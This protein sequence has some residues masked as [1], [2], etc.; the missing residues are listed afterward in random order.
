MFGIRQ[1]GGALSTR[2]DANSISC[3]LDSTSICAVRIC[4]VHLEVRQIA[5]ISDRKTTGRR[6]N[7]WLLAVSLCYHVQRGNSS[8]GRAM[9]IGGTSGS[10]LPGRL[11]A[12]EN[13]N[14]SI[15]LEPAQHLAATTERR[16]LPAG[17]CAIERLLS[18]AVARAN[19]SL[20]CKN[21]SSMSI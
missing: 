11:G 18:W 9:N 1:R 13:A 4:R 7:T 21:V 19:V 17:C 10:Q 2:T 16:E 3:L 6:F 5:R 12:I 8:V 15:G 14:E 20:H